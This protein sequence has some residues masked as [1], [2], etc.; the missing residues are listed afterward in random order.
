M[1]L[2]KPASLSL[3]PAYMPLCQLAYWMLVTERV[4]ND[5]DSERPWMGFAGIVSPGDQPP[6]EFNAL[7]LTH[8]WMVGGLMA[9]Y[10]MAA[11]VFL[12]LAV[13]FGVFILPVVF[14]IA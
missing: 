9:V 5:T 8:A 4:N 3:W 7:T 12:P 1:P 2:F 13:V 14:G 11:L 10:L 6:F